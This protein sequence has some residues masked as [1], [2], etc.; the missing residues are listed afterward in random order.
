M[1][2]SEVR[3]ERGLL[4]RNN[5]NLP[6]DHMERMKLKNS[7]GV[8]GDPENTKV[9]TNRSTTTRLPTCLFLLVVLVMGK[10]IKVE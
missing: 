7:A 4:E 2:S 8:E 9:E 5:N 1:S 6:R 10:I 3:R